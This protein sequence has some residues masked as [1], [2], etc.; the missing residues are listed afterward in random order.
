MCFHFIDLRSA[1]MPMS[2][3]LVAIEPK[4]RRSSS[5]P[6]PQASTNHPATLLQIREQRQIVRWEDSG[7]LDII[8]RGNVQSNIANNQNLFWSGVPEHYRKVVVVGVG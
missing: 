7:G 5:L 8:A 2:L 1:V 6:P 4:P 3:G